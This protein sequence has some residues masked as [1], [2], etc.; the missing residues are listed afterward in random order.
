ME[1][2]RS[3]NTDQTEFG[4]V[5]RGFAKMDI[6]RSKKYHMK[7]NMYK[8]QLNTLFDVS[9]T[10]CDELQQSEHPTILGPT[11]S[12]FSESYGGDI[13]E[14]DSDFLVNE[15]K[16]EKKEKAK[17]KV[18]QSSNLLSSMDRGNVSTR[19]AN[20]LVTAAIF[21]HGGSVAVA[22]TSVSY[23][24][25]HRAQTKNRTEVATKIR[26]LKF[27]NFRLPRTGMEQFYQRSTGIRKS[28]A[29]QLL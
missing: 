5:H 27:V 3:T 7:I 14:N 29:S 1:K 16:S 11:L 25:I 28:I 26:Q 4:S 13:D 21:A 19:T 17:K 24:T 8:Q 23:S 6:A 20:L 9:S 22:N 10:K 12:K 2:I 18:K 15:K